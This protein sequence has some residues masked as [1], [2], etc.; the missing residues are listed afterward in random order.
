MDKIHPLDYV[1]N[2]LGCEIKEIPKPNN[3]DNLLSEADYIY[4]FLYTTGASK[5]QI[6]SIYKITKSNHDKNFN[7]KNYENR[8]IF[9]HGTKV[10]NFIGILSQ[11]LK[12][13][14][15]QAKFTGSAYGIGIYL[16][17]SFSV[18][19]G[20]CRANYNYSNKNNKIYMLLVE[21]AVGNVGPNDDTN[22]V[23]MSL[24]FNDAFITNEGYG[25]FINSQKVN[26]SG[27]IVARDETNVRVKYIVEIQ[28]NYF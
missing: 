13:A 11:G 3:T 20:Y 14:P 1:I 27:V 7:L 9:C 17:D 22:I 28:N 18:S 5:N 25:I 2:C 15:V 19:L 10:E 12:I 8:F 21:V 16:S 26:A 23:S 24:K 4:N 6:K